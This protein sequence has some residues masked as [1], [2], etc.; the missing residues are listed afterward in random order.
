MYIVGLAFKIKVKVYLR[1][2]YYPW[3]KWSIMYKFSGWSMK[4]FS[5]FSFYNFSP[6]SKNFICFFFSFWKQVY[7]IRPVIS[8]KCNCRLFNSEMSLRSWSCFWCCCCWNCWSSLFWFVSSSWQ[9]VWTVDR[10]DS[11]FSW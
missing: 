3:I 8:C 1:F 2:R 4:G 5:T 11:S 7:S 10:S 6:T 9:S